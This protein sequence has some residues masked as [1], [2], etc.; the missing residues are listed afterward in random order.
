MSSN[1]YQFRTSTTAD[2][3]LLLNFF[4]ET[5]RQIDLLV[6]RQNRIIDSL[7]DYTRMPSQLFQNNTVR[8]SEAPRRPVPQYRAPTYNYY[9][10]PTPETNIEPPSEP[11]PTPTSQQNNNTRRNN[12]LSMMDNYILYSIIPDRNSD[13]NAD[14][15]SERVEM[16]LEEFFNS[17]RVRA[18][19]QQIQGATSECVF[20]SINEPKN[21]TCPITLNVFQRNDTVTKINECGH[22]YTPSALTE[23]FNNNVHCPLCRYDI[24]DNV[25]L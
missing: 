4:N 5:S 23:W 22:L 15:N 25:N 6:E 24:R 10:E 8:E 13:R 11:N 1:G 3:M 20:G 19:Q 17:V 9:P 18:T 2:Y 12:G 7:M 14:R 21:T 16:L